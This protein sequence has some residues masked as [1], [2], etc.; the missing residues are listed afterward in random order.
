MGVILAIAKT[1][2]RESI[3]QRVLLVVL[4]LGLMLIGVSVAFSYLSTGEEF[5]FVLDFGLV[6]ITLVGLGLAVILGGFMIPNDI[7]R[8]VVFTI[9]SKPVSRLQY[10]LGK[11]LGACAVIFV[12]D[13]LMGL[14]FVVAYVAKHPQHEYTWLLPLAVLFVFLQTAVLLAVALCLSTIASPVFTMI[15]T[16]FVYIVGAV[17]AH[18][19]Y[20]SDRAASTMLKITFGIL[21][22]LVPNFT[23]FDLRSTLFLG[24]PVGLDHILQVLG[25]TVLY[26]GVLTAV[27][28]LLF[29]EREF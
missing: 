6:G 18:I 5:R 9:L 10:L 25:Y 22:K 13:A 16:G 17:N 29:N 24:G 20:L 1:T 21:A 15:A 23:N 11:L 28:W 4:L 14:A 19:V 27:A 7:D 8:R 2:Y 26:V 12:L 3:R